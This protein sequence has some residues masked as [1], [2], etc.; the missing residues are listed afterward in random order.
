DPRDAVKA[1][2]AARHSLKNRRGHND[3]A[4]Q[5]LASSLLSQHRF[6][7]ALEISKQLR[8]RNPQAAP[9]RAAV[10]E[11]QMELGRYDSARVAFQALRNEANDL[12]IAP[13][14]A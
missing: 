1:E 2:E 14:L 7:E 5:V 3:E 11:I 12:A 4:A 9:L 8:D 13:R 10:A 6:T